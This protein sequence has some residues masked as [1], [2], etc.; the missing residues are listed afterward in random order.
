MIYPILEFDPDRRSI[1]E[2]STFYQPLTNVNY[3]VMSFFREIIEKV[4]IEKKARRISTM[5]SEMGEHPLFIMEHLGTSIG[6]FHPGIGAPLAAG[7]FEEVIAHGFSKF[8]A[9]GGA[10]V[11]QKEIQVGKI[12]IPCSAVRDEGTSY[13][14]V[15]PSRE[16]TIPKENVDCLAKELQ[17]QQV[18]YI[19]GKT[20][21]TDAFYRETQQKIETRRKEGCITVEM[22]CSALAAVAQFRNVQFAQY[23]YGGDDVS[24]KQ[25]DQRKWNRCEVREKLFWASVNACLRL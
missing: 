12:I 23:L 14:Y 15:E 4:S 13:H 3:C 22:E 6:F 2:P 10:G 9:C 24:G 16:I 11:L 1:I 5:R 7:L 20:W 21:T 18:E 19:I 17:K 25:W 8:V